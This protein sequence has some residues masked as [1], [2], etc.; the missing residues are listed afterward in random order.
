MIQL[1]NP[2]FDACQIWVNLLFFF[3]WLWI[4]L[5]KTKKE[6]F[7]VLGSEYTRILFKIWNFIYRGRVIYSHMSQFTLLVVYDFIDL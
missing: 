6:L 5:E 2:S 3:V 4:N 7:K 1:T